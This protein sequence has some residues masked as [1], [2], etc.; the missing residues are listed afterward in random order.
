MHMSS[1]KRPR[2]TSRGAAT[3]E[4]IVA[5]AAAL[6]YEGGVA[7]TSLDEIM[8]ATGTSKSQL[9]HYFAD[10]DALVLEVIRRQLAQVV[11]GQ[12][13]ELREL[14]SWEGMRRWRDHMVELT[15]V[16]GGIGGCPLG[17]LA[18]E[19]ADR[20]EPAREVL[21]ACF[22][23]WEAYFVDGFTA[24]RKDGLLS[25]GADPAEL[26]VTVMTALQGGLLLAQTTRDVRPLE[27][28]LDMAIAHVGQYR[29]G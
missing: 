15:R 20:S 10:K 1:T 25:P 18:S 22:S 19:L 13:T 3:R 27:L 9:Y 23:E 14:R 26:A 17:S 2:L 6:I 4:R 29:T 16:T 24:M 11:A 28:A 8:A 21:T 7:C 5:G 12:E